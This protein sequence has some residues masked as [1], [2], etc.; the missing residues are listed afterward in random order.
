[1]IQQKTIEIENQEI[2]SK[3][4]SKTIALDIG[5]TLTKIVCYEKE[6]L[7]L[8]MFS[9]RNEFNEIKSVLEKNTG[10]F[11]EVNF[12]GGKA[13]N[14]YKNYS[15]KY[16]TNL[17]NEFEA[18]LNG[19]KTLYYLTKEKLLNP[20]LITSFGTG[21]SIVLFDGDIKHLGGSAMGGGYFMGLAKI[22]SNITDY[23]E[24]ID[25]ASKGNRYQVDLKVS[26]I[27]SPEDN[28][29][30]DL[31]R[32]FTAASYAK[33]EGSINFASLK[34]EDLLNSLICLIGENIGTIVNLH[35]EI[36]NLQEIVFCGGF[37]IN[38]GVLKK[39]LK[40]ICRLNNNRAIFLKNSEYSG[41]IGALLI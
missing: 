27:Y 20:C 2:R 1:M 16:K 13:F 39:I 22:I 36:H 32:E 15:S 17:I 10:L 12:T 6:R 21:T 34:K 8:L 26:D 9:T 28:R 31:F 30:S 37:L 38:N 11:K 7:K 41:A 5:Q 40:L 29:I 35:A 25:F 24:A 19:I 14:L 33:I 18:N 23:K 4:P 3:F